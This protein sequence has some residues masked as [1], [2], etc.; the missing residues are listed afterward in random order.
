MTLTFCL[1][2]LR[3][4]LYYVCDVIFIYT[5]PKKET[6]AK[7][8]PVVEGNHLDVHTYVHVVACK[9]RIVCKICQLIPFIQ[10]KNRVS[11]ARKG[12]AYPLHVVHICV[13]QI[14]AIVVQL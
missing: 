14:I 7:Y 4:I 2:S 1:K 8:E 9:T 13:Y 3:N 12:Y 6:F 10:R 5:E 11:R